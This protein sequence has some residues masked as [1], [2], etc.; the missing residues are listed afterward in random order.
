MLHLGFGHHVWMMP[1]QNLEPFLKHLFATYFIV[2]IGLT[3]A[4]A[5]ALLFLSRVFPHTTNPTWF[6]VGVAV[7]HFLN[8]AWLVGMSFGTAFNCNPVAKNWDVTG[9]LPGKCGPTSSIWIASVVPSVFIDLLILVLPLPRIWTIKT[10]NSRKIGLTVVFI[11]GYLAVVISVG[12]TITV[13]KGVD[14]INNDFTYEGVANVYW[15]TAE[16]PCVLLG[17]CLP[18]MLNLGRHIKAN[19]LLPMASST[20]RVRLRYRSSRDASKSQASDISSDT[21]SASQSTGFGQAQ[22]STAKLHPP[23]RGFESIQVYNAPSFAYTHSEPPPLTQPQN[24]YPQSSYPQS[25]YPQIYYPQIYYPQS[26]YHASHYAAQ[27]G[28]NNNTAGT[29]PAVPQRFI[30]VDS[31]FT[32]SH[33]PYY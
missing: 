14:E 8:V 6:N 27:I 22:H 24:H 2:Y 1:S 31:N 23:E 9:T 32:V 28:S 16:G 25:H 21:P 12:R 4:K 17:V 33:Q 11:I 18:P 15:V 3:L 30:D 29:P 26:C 20:E 10:S 5:S 13:L 19:Y 7:T